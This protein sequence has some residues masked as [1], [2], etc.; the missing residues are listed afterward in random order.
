[1]NGYA[2]RLAAVA[3]LAIAAAQADAE[4]YGIGSPASAADIAAWDR[5]VNAAGVGLP[6]GS[7]TAAEG[8]AVYQAQCAACHGPAG[9]GGPYDRL[10]S[11]FAADNDFGGD[12]SVRR[13]IGNFWPYAT[14]L[15]DYVQRAMPLTAPGS[16]TPDEVYALVAYLLSANGII[17]AHQPVDAGNLASIR[18]P[19]RDLFFWSAESRQLE[20]QPLPH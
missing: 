1:M 4:G 5:D 16:L 18:M 6:P 2:R 13:T 14:T 3:M 8:A 9:E 15:Y 11:P 7:G 12:Y 20:A 10:V 17:G 19:A